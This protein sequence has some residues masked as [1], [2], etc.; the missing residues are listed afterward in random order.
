MATASFTDALRVTTSWSNPNS[1]PGGPQ[2]QSLRAVLL[3]RAL[4]MILG[5][6]DFEFDKEEFATRYRSMS[7]GEL[8]ELAL[9]SAGLSEP[10]WEALEDEFDRRDL[11]FPEPD[12]SLQPETPEIRNLTML[13]RF[14]DLPEALLAQGKLA[15]EGIESYL[16]DNNTVRMDWLWSNLVGGV[17]LLVAAED[18]N[19]ANQVLDQPIPE[20]I[21]FDGVAEYQQPRCPKCQSLDI[22]FE[23]LYKPIAYGSLFVNF[24]IPMQRSG[25]TCHT[26]GNTW[27]ESAE[28]HGEANDRTS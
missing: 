13:K 10:A 2:A 8:L 3:L 27:H 16:A 12:P 4:G 6:S 14:R 18:A 7:D 5:M 23:E 1:P 21:N 17:K 26:C 25:W 9:K 20:E 15:S 22:N 11:E 24:P 28:A 19:P